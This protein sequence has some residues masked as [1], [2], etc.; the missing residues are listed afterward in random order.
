MRLAFLA[1][2]LVVVDAFIIFTS[3][4]R[5]QCSLA[6]QK[7]RLNGAGR[8]RDNAT[9]HKRS[10]T[11]DSYVKQ[12]RPSPE[13]QRALDL[14]RS[15][16]TQPHAFPLDT[17]S[18]REQV[19]L[20]QE[21]ERSNGHDIIFRLVQKHDTLQQQVLEAAIVALS[22]A[23]SHQSQILDILKQDKIQSLSSSTCASLFDNISSDVEA[24]V[25][26]DELQHYNNSVQVWNAALRACR[27]QGDAQG[28]DHDNWQVALSMLRD[29]KRSGVTPNERSYGEVLNACAQ[30]GQVRIALS[31]LKELQHQSQSTK[32]KLSPQI[33]GAALHACAKAGTL[34]DAISILQY[35]TSQNIP[36]NTVHISAFLSTCAKVGR[37][38]IA[39]QLLESFRREDPFHSPEYN[40]V[41]PSTSVDLVVMNTV[42]LACAKAGNYGAAKSILQEIKQ[43]AFDRVEHPDVISYNTVLSACHDPTEAKAIVKEVRHI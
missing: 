37:D 7:T 42:L 17:L 24:A 4:P 22:S 19:H 21:L 43:G 10:R 5:R 28:D 11:R 20:I 23:P 29:M 33:W 9:R 30:V 1:I 2:L 34:H 12:Q 27:R 16:V 25:L 39:R 18:T 8:Q 32:S 35:M 40:L 31:L 15:N 6:K 13:V 3:P 36:I 41:I 26:M 14:F 38:D